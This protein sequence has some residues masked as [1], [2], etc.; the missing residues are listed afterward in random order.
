MAS[1]YCGLI[2]FRVI[3]RKYFVISSVHEKTNSVP[4]RPCWSL[5]QGKVFAFFA[6]ATLLEDWPGSSQV[7]IVEELC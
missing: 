1:R 5:V 4:I 3:Q 6:S 7:D 2:F